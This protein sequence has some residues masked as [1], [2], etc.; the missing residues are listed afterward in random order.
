MPGFDKPTQIEC[1]GIG[2]YVRIVFGGKQNPQK[3]AKDT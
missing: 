3:H 1:L 2:Q